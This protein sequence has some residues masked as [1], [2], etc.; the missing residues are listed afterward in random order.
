M[1]YKDTLN[2][3]STRFPMKAKLAKREVEQ[4]NSWE[5]DGLY[6]KIRTIS[7]DRKQFILHDGPPYANGNI[8]MGT[9]LNKILKDIIVRSDRCQDLMQNMCLAGIAMVFPLNIMLTRSLGKKSRKKPES[10]SAA[11]AE[12]MRKNMSISSAMNLKGLE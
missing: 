8:H 3:P 9:A 10:K 6:K 1:D 4:L 7:K 12:N 5:K 11:Y 2:L